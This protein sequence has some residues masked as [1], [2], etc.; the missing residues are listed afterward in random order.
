MTA[1]ATTYRLHGPEGLGDVDLLAL[2]LGHRPGAV[3]LLEAFGSLSAI[4]A[5][6]PAALAAQVG[7]ARAARLHAAFALGR[8]ALEAGTPRARV[9]SASDAGAWLVPRLAGLDHE[10][11]HVL[12]LDQRQG[13]IAARRMSSGGIDQTV[14]DV[15]AILGEA[16]RVAARAIIVGHNHPSGDREPSREDLLVTRRLA[17]GAAILGMNLLD[18]LIVAGGSYASMAERGDLLD[19]RGFGGSGA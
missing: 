7:A 13:V 2:I 17:E 8:R 3:L 12:F 10:E 5:A 14:V 16:I 19:A 18:H 11:L 6:T 4:A 15:R 1:L 9:R